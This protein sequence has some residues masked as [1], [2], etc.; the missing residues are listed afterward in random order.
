MDPD[1]RC[2][3]YWTWWCS[4]NYV[5][6]PE[7]FHE[8]ILGKFFTHFDKFVISS[9]TSGGSQPPGLFQRASL[10]FIHNLKCYGSH[11][12]CSPALT[13]NVWHM[14]YVP[15]WICLHLPRNAVFAGKYTIWV[16]VSNIF[17]FHPYLG[18]W[19]N[20]TNMFQMGWNHQLDHMLR[21]WLEVCQ[22][23]PAWQAAFAAWF[24][25]FSHFAVKR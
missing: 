22:K 19:S 2:I 10:L 6:L 5:S 24:P 20:L 17:Y 21:V 11:K 9:K 8:L 25:T 14:V 12:K 7:G 4:T 23:F 15:L 18:K 13:L 16:V 3:S 1:W